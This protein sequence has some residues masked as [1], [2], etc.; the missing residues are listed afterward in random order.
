VP[1]PPFFKPQAA[2]LHSADN[3]KTILANAVH[4]LPHSVK[5]WLHAAEL[6]TE[7]E[8]KKTVIIRVNHIHNAARTFFFFFFSNYLL[9]KSQSS[10]LELQ[11]FLSSS[12]SSSCHLLSFHYHLLLTGASTRPR[13][14]A[15]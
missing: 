8:R 14:R 7:A 15:Q 4:H 3:A 2:R 13:V 5:I 12:W 10:P 11:C 1:P 6:E 9:K